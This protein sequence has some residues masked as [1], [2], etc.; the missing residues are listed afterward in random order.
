MTKIVCASTIFVV[1]DR[2]R[3]SPTR[4]EFHSEHRHIEPEEVVSSQIAAGEECE[5]LR[6]HI[7][8][9]RRSLHIR[10]RDMMNGRRGRRDGHAR[11]ETEMPLLDRPEIQAALHERDIDDPVIDRIEPGGF[12]I[13]EDKGTGE[14]EHGDRVSV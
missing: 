11:I 13:E 4:L 6:G 2:D 3:P 7:L 10:I 1:S 5:H 9:R 14:G 8:E 12:D